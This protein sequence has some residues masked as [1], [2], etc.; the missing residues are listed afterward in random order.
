MV[1]PTGQISFNN[2]N[3][4]LQRGATAQLSASDEWFYAMGNKAN[5]SDVGGNPRGFTISLDDCRGG[6][7]HYENG[8]NIT[9]HLGVGAAS[10]LPSGW[11]DGYSG[12]SIDDTF[13]SFNIAI[14]PFWI[15]GD[16]YSSRHIGSN[17]YITFTSGSTQYANLSAANPPYP[18]IM[19]QAADNSFQR[20]AYKYYDPMGT[21]NVRHLR[22][23]WEGTAATGG[24]AGSPNM[25]WELT[26]FSD[27]T[28]PLYKGVA[29]LLIGNMSR[30]GG[31][32]G[33]ADATS[34]YVTYGGAANSSY[35]FYSESNG[36]SWFRNENRH[37]AGYPT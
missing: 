27:F 5:Q 19:I 30:S 14:F 13:L 11:S 33:V 32:N 21:L 24:T 8:Y 22:I 20:V 9:P 2:I 18:K 3:A 37:R 1:L 6:Y 23:R 17:S 35:T 7:Y 16:G 25:V 28:T 34:Y 15:A 26:L 29:D 36:N 4:E 12:G 31:Q 10:W